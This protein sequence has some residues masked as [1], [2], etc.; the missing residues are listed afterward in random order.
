M[1][2]IIR[3]YQGAWGS[4]PFA[5]R[6]VPATSKLK[7]SLLTCGKAGALLLTRRSLETT[8][9]ERS[10]VDPVKETRWFLSKDL[11]DSPV[12]P[13][14]W[15]VKISNIM[16]KTSF[17]FRMNDMS[18]QSR[19]LF[20]LLEIF[21]YRHVIPT[22]FLIAEFERKNI[23]NNLKFFTPRHTGFLSYSLS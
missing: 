20:K 8:P 10:L 17:C 16:K 14:G 7:A 3:I 2:Q 23:F 5:R 18:V 4:R 12:G 19:F 21:R 22:G 1:R 6:S 13:Y 15:G 9:S 11:F